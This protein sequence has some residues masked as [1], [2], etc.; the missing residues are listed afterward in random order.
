MLTLYIKSVVVS[1]TSTVLFHENF[2]L[3]YLEKCELCLLYSIEF[4]SDRNLK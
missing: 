4:L 1:D 2:C 3:R